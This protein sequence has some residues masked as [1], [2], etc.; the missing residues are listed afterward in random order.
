MST[1]S[2]HEAV[3]IPYIK[4][5]ASASRFWII[6]NVPRARNALI[7][8]IFLLSLCLVLKSKQRLCS[9]SLSRLLVTLR[10]TAETLKKTTCLAG[11]NR[12]SR[13]YVA[14]KVLTEPRASKRSRGKVDVP[15]FDRPF[16]G[17]RFVAHRR[18]LADEAAPMH[19]APLGKSGLFLAQAAPPSA[20]TTFSR[21]PCGLWTNRSK[22]LKIQDA[23]RMAVF[24]RIRKCLCRSACVMNCL[25]ACVLFVRKNE[26]WDVR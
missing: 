11:Y 9:F 23:P 8:A 7:N 3:C 24:S 1:S 18:S 25:A 4:K 5:T 14:T 2:R 16:F 26:K 12:S 17:P 15:Y 13:R 22:I 6:I 20:F 21:E 10:Q 19:S